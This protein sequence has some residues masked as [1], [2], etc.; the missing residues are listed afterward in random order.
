MSAQAT[1]TDRDVRHLV[2]LVEEGA[3][4][5]D[6]WPFPS[7]VL[8]GLHEIVPCDDVTFQLMDARRQ[9]VTGLWV[10]GQGAV[11][12]MAEDDDEGGLSDLFWS[13]FWEYGGCSYQQITGDYLS[14]QRRSDEFSDRE[15]ATTIMGDFMRQVGMRHEVLVPLPPEGYLDYRI[16]LFRSEGPDFSDREVMLLRMLRP[17]LAE[18]H[19]RRQ[20]QF[21]GQ[22]ELTPRQWEILRR[23]AAGASNAEVARA[24]HVSQATVRKHLEH[25]FLRLDVASRT[26]AVATVTPFLHAI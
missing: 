14:I 12:D 22:P 2:Q 18:L 9:E 26:E 8:I 13:G 15:Y 25:I 23:V 6:S 10:D 7:S 1:V 20:R 19:A 17:H 3:E 21:N 4:A 11:H 16:L 24:L 5:D